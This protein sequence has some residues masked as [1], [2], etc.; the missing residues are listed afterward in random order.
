MHP[1]ADQH[2]NTGCPDLSAV[3][4]FALQANHEAAVTHKSK[5]VN[6]FRRVSRK[7]TPA[8]ILK[9]G[10]LKSRQSKRINSLKTITSDNL[11]LF[12]RIQD[13]K[14]T[15][16]LTELHKELSCSILPLAKSHRTNRPQQQH[17]Q[18]SFRLTV[19]CS[20]AA[21]LKSRCASLRHIST[22]NPSASQRSSQLP[23][24]SNTHVAASR[25]ISKLS[26]LTDK[27]D[28]ENIAVNRLNPK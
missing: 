27:N 1:L 28:K 24:E 12:L 9:E 10:I 20:S 16:K 8:D 13:Q 5:S 17:E 11:K 14:S 22:S 6:K 18:S 7:K 26:F 2:Q 21:S 25:A 4:L 15:Y 3:N 19:R 23:S